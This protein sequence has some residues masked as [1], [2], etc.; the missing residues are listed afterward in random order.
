MRPNPGFYIPN[1]VTQIGIFEIGI[2]ADKCEI[3][4]IVNAADIELYFCRKVLVQL[5]VVSEIGSFDLESCG[6]VVIGIQTVIEM[7]IDLSRYKPWTRFFRDTVL[8]VNK[9]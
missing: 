2:P 7:G 3:R 4:I 9:G 1:A 6:R 8:P 5:P